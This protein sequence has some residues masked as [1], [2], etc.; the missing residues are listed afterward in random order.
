MALT[1]FII[2]RAKYLGNGKSR[3]VIWDDEIAGFGCRIYP[4]GKK[5]FILFYRYQGTQK[6]M[7]LGAYGVITVQQARD[8]AKITLVRILEGADPLGD[9]KRAAQ[10]ETIEDLCHTFIEKHAKPHKKSWEKDEWRLKTH[11]SPIWGKR[12]ITSIQRVDVAHLHHEVGKTR[13]IYEANRTLALL[14]KLFEC[15]KQWSIH[16][17]SLA[18]PA[19]K[20]QRFKEEKRDRWVKPEELPKLAQ[21][22]DSE[23]NVYIKAAIWLYLLT[24][25]RREELLKVR[26]TDLD[27]ARCELRISDT[28]NNQ[29]H[30]VPLSTHAMNLIQRIP[31]LDGNPYILPGRVTGKPIVNITKPWLRI[32]KLAEIEDVRLHDL[33]RTCGSWLAQSGNSLQLIGKVLNHKNLKTTEVYARLA[34]DQVRTALE[35]H[36]N[37]LLS[38][39]NQFKKI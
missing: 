26:W 2:E 5:S 22:I 33:R 15:A 4:T 20:I 38:I 11:V 27:S 9:R 24:G 34:E 12:K 21:A 16:P 7:T 10:A 6:L 37:Q 32:R 1:K 30:Y 31:R 14:S 28:K 23:S 17:D 8:K 19:K 3:H 36:G 25:V 35:N 39:A 18:N 29:P 13:G